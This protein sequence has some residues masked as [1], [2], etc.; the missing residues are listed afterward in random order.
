MKYSLGSKVLIVFTGHR[1]YVKEV[2]SDGKYLVV[3]RHPVAKRD[4]EHIL[5]ESQISSAST[6]YKL[7]FKSTCVPDSKGNFSK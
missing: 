7:D 3:A 5:E 4:F 2:L 1:G 6:R